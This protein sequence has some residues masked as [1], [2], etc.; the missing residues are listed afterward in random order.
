MRGVDREGLN[1]LLLTVELDSLE[2]VCEEMIGLIR[3]CV[4]EQYEEAQISGDELV[5]YT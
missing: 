5:I 1:D 2:A 3:E 4:P